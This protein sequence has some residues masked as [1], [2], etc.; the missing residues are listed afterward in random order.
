[1]FLQSC[2][3]ALVC[4]ITKWQRQNS[5]R[6]ELS[7]HSSP[8]SPYLRISL[9]ELACKNSVPSGKERGEMAV[10]AGYDSFTAKIWS[11]QMRQKWVEEGHKRNDYRLSLISIFLFPALPTFR[12]PF[13]FTS[14]PLSSSLEQARQERVWPPAPCEAKTTKESIKT[15]TEKGKIFC[16]RVV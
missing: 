11:S 6:K 16:I 1:M 10:F 3:L 7:T 4:L 9:E 13:T 8:D 15:K 14:S 2:C 12:V 5:R